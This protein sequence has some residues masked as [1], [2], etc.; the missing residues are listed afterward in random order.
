MFIGAYKLGGKELEAPA[1]FA[2]KAMAELLVTGFDAL[3]PHAELAVAV[4]AAVGIILPVLRRIES[5]K[6]YVPSG[7]AMGIAFI[8][9]PSHSLVMFYGL[10]VWLIWKMLWPAAAEKYTFAVASGLI[11]GEGLMGIVNAGLTMAGVPS[12]T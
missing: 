3:P 9:T 8:I 11:A 7:L 10:V 2:W 4:A 5:I 6:A 1:A 12:L